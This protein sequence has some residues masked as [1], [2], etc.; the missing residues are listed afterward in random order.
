[1]DQPGKDNQVEDFLSRINNSSESVPVVDSFPNEHL[2]S[3]STKTLCFV[4]V[5]NYLSTQKLPSHLSSKE[6]KKI[7]NIVLNIHG[8]KEI[9]STQD[10]I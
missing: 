4:D 3:I 9:F 6:K 8:S 10:Q 1:M 5:A 2:F 7:N